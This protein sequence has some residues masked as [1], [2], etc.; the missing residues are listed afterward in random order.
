MQLVIISPHL[1]D[2]IYS[3]WWLLIELKN[4]SDITIINIFSYSNY[5]NDGIWNPKVISKIRQTEDKYVLE[6]ISKK[7]INLNFYDALLRYYDSS[8]LFIDDEILYTIIK[9]KE[10]P[11]IRQISSTIKQNITSKNSILFFPSWFGGHVDHLICRIVWEIYEHNYTVLYY[12]EIPYITRKKNI[13]LANSFVK[14]L[15]L[16][17]IKTGKKNYEQHH[18]LM[19]QYRSQYKKQYNDLIIPY[20]LTYWYQLWHRHDEKTNESLSQIED[21]IT[22]PQHE[23]IKVPDEQDEHIGL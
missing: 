20:L 4:I 9:E 22:Q 16:T 12:G 1:D 18:Y 3:L 17:T 21:Q 15:K 5:S 2:A 23:K 13:T 14:N 19:K 8:T 10:L 7:I 6:N 11:L